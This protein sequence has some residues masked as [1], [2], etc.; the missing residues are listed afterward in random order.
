MPTL[1]KGIK[2]PWIKRKPQS[3]KGWGSDHRIYNS[4][5]WRRLRLIGLNK[6]PL[7]ITCKGK[8]ITK[9]ATVRDHIIPIQQ[10]GSIWDENN[11]QSLCKSCHNRKSG[12][13]KRNIN[14][15]QTK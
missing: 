15:K 2:R 12:K 11:H 13:E 9:A 3:S 14:L 6:E 7:C 10:G 1:P 8:G 4:D 5:R